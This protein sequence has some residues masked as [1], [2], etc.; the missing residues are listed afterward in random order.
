M[1]LN[2]PRPTSASRSPSKPL[3][4]AAQKTGRLKK[5][6]SRKR[7]GSRRRSKAGKRLARQE[8]KV[9]NRR[10][11]HQ[12]KVSKRIIDENQAVAAERLK[13]IN[14]QKNHHQAG[15]L[16]RRRAWR[17][18]AEDCLQGDAEGEE[19]RAD[20]H[21]LRVLQAVERLW[22]QARRAQSSP[23]GSGRVPSAGRITTR[24]VNAAK[25]IRREGI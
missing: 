17:S 15:S 2:A 16:G 23:C 21:I 14:M 6:H 7:I 22:K 4:K 25:N 10:E 18:S 5:P 8:R 20:R 1:S 11:D 3:R 19:V 24:N 13:I 9:R 12:H